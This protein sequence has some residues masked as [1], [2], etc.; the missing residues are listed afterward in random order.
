MDTSAGG[1]ERFSL[2]Q[3]A[4]RLGFPEG[5]KEM[6]TGWDEAMRAPAPAA[7]DTLKPEFIAQAGLYGGMTGEMI[8]AMNAFAGRI[9]ADENALA[10]Y[11]YAYHRVRTDLSLT[12]EWN[13]PWP[14]LDG[15]FGPEAGLFNALVALSGVP[16]MKELHHR[17]GI[18][19]DV[20]RDTAGDI[21]RWMESDLYYQ[22]YKVW[23]ITPWLMAWLSRHR[24]GKVFQIKRLHF[25]AKGFDGRLKAYRNRKTREVVAISDPGVKYLADGNLHG[26]CCGEIPGTWT[27]TLEET[28][29]AVTGNPILPAGLARREKV[30]LPLSEWELVL[31]Q[32]DPVLGI[33]I[34]TGSPMTFEECGESYRKAL[35][36]YP[37]YFPEFKSRGFNTS[38]WL[39]DTKLE[40]LL[41]P[42]SNI[43]KMMKEFYLYPGTASGNHGF[44]ERVFGWGI[45]DIKG[46]PRN[47][48]LQK[49][50]GDFAD[51]GGHFHGGSCLLLNEDLDWGTGVYRSRRA[52]I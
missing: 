2:G 42:E 21:R 35:E 36:F 34:P 51:K 14:A 28:T 29:D 12:E 46:L 11:R 15:H 1:P 44:F 49:A 32:G 23:G 13:A 41:S 50:I 30:R 24:H 43:V 22:R 47:T 5:G 9:R 17:L 25:T 16:E 4:E 48:S 33:H 37:K 45:T 40:Q 18:P 26:W 7:L 3:V 10:F 27:S 6:C 38:S 8:G 31:K 52:V 20:T 19:E 39:L